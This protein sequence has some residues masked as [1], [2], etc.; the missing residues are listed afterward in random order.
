MSVSPDTSP[1]PGLASLEAGDPAEV[2]PYR[3]VGRIGAGGMGAVFGALDVYG[4]CVAVKTVHADIARESR[5]REAF[6]REVEMLGRADG[7]ST[8]RL[9]AADTEAEVPWLAFDY[10]PGRD[11]RAHVREF[12]P[13]AGGMLRTFALGAAEG[14][15]ALHAAGIAHRDVKPGNVILSPDGPKIVDFGIAVEVGTENS[16]DPSSSYG[17]PGWTAPERYSGAVA[18]PSADVFA[19][20]GLVALAATG[21]EPFG[22]ADANELARRV[23]AGEHDV[24]GVPED[25]LGLVRAALS[26]DPKQRPNSQALVRALMPVPAEETQNQYGRP[27]ATADSLRGMLRDYW[28]G[29]DD[30]GHDPGRWAAALGV[31]SVVGLGT[32]AL[33]SG[34][35]GAGAMGS[36]GAAGSGAAAG[37]GAA[38][39]TA[40]AGPTVAGSGAVTAGGSAA[41]TATGGMM[42]GI[43]TSKLGL[44]GAGVLAVA[45]LAAGGFVV[46]NQVSESPSETVAAAAGVLE[47]SEGFTA[48][49]T[50]SFSQSHAERVAERTGTPVDQVVEGSLVEEEYLYSAADQTFLIRGAAMGPGTTGVANHRG[51]LY[52]YEQGPEDGWPLPERIEL[53]PGV[54]PESVA[55]TLVTEPLRALAERGEAETVEGQEGVYTGPTLFGLLD[56]GAFVETEAIARVELDEEGAPLWAEYTTDQREVRIDFEER[57]TRVPIED[58]QLWALDNDLRW[59]VVYAPVCGSILSGWPAQQEWDVQASGWDM[60][61]DDAMDIAGVVADSS[62]QEDRVTFLFGRF[63]R[64]TARAID[65][66][67]ACGDGWN[68]DFGEEPDPTENVTPLLPCRPITNFTEPT[69]ASPDFYDADIVPIILID[70]QLRD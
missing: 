48:R 34:V 14:L 25:L 22:K 2:G 70:F 40:G 68:L 24:E 52:V 57:D 7:V 23:K 39:G 18:D 11:L 26:V 51:D 50:R 8:A 4:R 37:A 31:A 45:G 35:V 3:V 9:H 27:P 30:A 10:V 56:E 44:A 36:G 55:V 21:R 16:D 60:S 58:P 32:S 12:G 65:E 64:S 61:C 6:A 42:S 41:G 46:Y 66:T 29:V 53:A 33:G 54:G 69:E 5:F 47:E 67:V 38:A 59:D 13:L 28:R 17:T 15:V 19:W 20:G 1:P 49:V 43:A 62:G 63:S